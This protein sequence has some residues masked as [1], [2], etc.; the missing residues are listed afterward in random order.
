MQI[1]LVGRGLRRNQSSERKAGAAGLHRVCRD[2]PLLVGTW[3]VGGAK[4]GRV[5]GTFQAEG[6]PSKG[7]K[8]GMIPACLGGGRGGVEVWSGTSR[9]LGDFRPWWEVSYPESRGR[10]G[11]TQLTGLCRGRAGRAGIPVVEGSVLAVR[12]RAGVCVHTQ[13]LGTPGEDPAGQEEMGLP[14]TE[15]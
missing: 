3:R 9:L 1:V 10:P 11:L 2:V 15:M 7:P 6:V 12:P 14:W 8:K 4:P 13:M 5:G